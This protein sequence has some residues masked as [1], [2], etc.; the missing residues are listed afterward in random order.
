ME[1]GTAITCPLSTSSLS[2]PLK[3]KP[4]LSPA[5]PSSR[6]FLNI[7]TPVQTDLV[8]SR[9]PTISTSSFTFTI[10]C[11]IL[12]VTTVPLPVIE[13]TSSTGIKKGLSTTLTGSS[14]YESTCSI[15]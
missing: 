9:I 10:P 12:P 2:I 6:S 13:K 14:I 5:L 3:S 1:P 8:V 15:N 11:S 4:T 7:S